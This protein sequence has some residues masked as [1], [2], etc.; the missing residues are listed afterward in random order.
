MEIER[1][2]L[3]AEKTLPK[4]LESYDFHEIEQAYLCTSPVVRIRR[5]DDT[6]Y[7][8]YKSK[9]FLSREE[10]NLPLTKDAYYH[11][12]EKADGIV[13]SKRRY[14]IP[15]SNGLTIELDIFHAPYDGLLLAEVEFSSEEEANAYQP[16]K[17]FGKDVTFSVSYHNSRL[18]SSLIPLDELL[19]Q[20]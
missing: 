19:S 6:Y 1:K 20:Q 15:E 11:L 4:D 10:Y 3:I 12:R 16:P 17:W 14:C 9:G 13:I 2:F 18:S 8:T 7:L 5:Q